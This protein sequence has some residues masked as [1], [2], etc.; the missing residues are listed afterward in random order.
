MACSLQGSSVHEIAQIR[1][2]E[3]V[4]MPSSIQR[5][6]PHLLC[7]L[8]W[9]ADCLPLCHLPICWNFTRL[10]TI[11]HIMAPPAER[12]NSNRTYFVAVQIPKHECTSEH[13]RSCVTFSDLALDVMQSLLHSISYKWGTSFH[14]FKERRYS[15]ILAWRIPWTDEPGRV[16]CITWQRV[17]HYWSNLVQHSTEW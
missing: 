12:S 1:I 16:Q 2:L 15:S 11:E 8:F 5:L 6:N 9:Q 14:R 4:V 10:S 17:G 13:N 7:L 3:W